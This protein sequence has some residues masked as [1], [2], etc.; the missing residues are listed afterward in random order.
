[1]DDE[2]KMAIISLLSRNMDLIEKLFSGSND[3]DFL[4]ALI[5]SK[6]RSR[7]EVRISPS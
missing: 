6:L 7:S 1:M 4:D 5:E 3:D 2:L